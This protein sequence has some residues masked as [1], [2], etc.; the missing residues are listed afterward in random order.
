MTETDDVARAL[1]AAATRWPEDRDRRARLVLRLLDEGYRA[2]R[3]SADRAETD[4]KDA[5]RRTSG[6]LSGVYG[7]G[8]LEQLR[9]DWPE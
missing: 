1:D 5:L 7:T 3:E 8:Y 4:R 2:L 9:R 6:L